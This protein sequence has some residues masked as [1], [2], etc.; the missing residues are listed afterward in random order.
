MILGAE[1]RSGPGDNVTAGAASPGSLL[2]FFGFTFAVTWALY[3]VAGAAVRG[4]SDADTTSRAL[5]ELVFLPGTVAPAAVAIWLTARE[6]GSAGVRAL[7]GRVLEWRV[8]ARWYL[9]AVGYMASVKL[10]AALGHRVATGEW[11]AFG[12]TPVLLMAS[13][14]VFSTPIQ[15]GEEVGWRGYALPR[16]AARLG[17][18][19]ASVLLGAI[20]ATWH[21][22]LF[23]LPGIPKT[24]ESFSLFLP[25][26]TALSVAM[27]WLYARTRGS[28]LLVM[29]MH[30]AVNNTTGIVPGAAPGA[31]DGNPFTLDASLVAWL[32][33]ALL[34][35][36]AAWFLVRM[37]RGGAGRELRHEGGRHVVEGSSTAHPS[38]GGAGPP[39]AGDRRNE[40]PPRDERSPG[41]S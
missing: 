18:G 2:R 9:F 28:L 32:T 12:S 1:P 5:L 33:V 10:T 40:G 29:L 22:P 11:P 8:G 31:T 23:V 20:W 7:L 21:L 4:G 19:P 39:G 17:L 13:A 26:V 30:A 36:P 27:A 37:G 15:A 24:G 6:Q 14:V 25:G 3:L 35:I 34:W 38:L 16:L 41:P